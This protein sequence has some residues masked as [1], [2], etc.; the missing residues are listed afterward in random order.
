MKR[1][2]L[3]V[4][5]LCAV[6]F[7]ILVFP[8]RRAVVD[9]TYIHLQYARNLAETGQLAFNRGDPTYGA[10]SPLWAGGDLLLWCKILALLAAVGSIALVYRLARSLAVGAFA[11]AAAALI[12][13]CEAWLVRWSAVGMETPFAVFMVLLALVAGL[14]AVRS[15]GRSVLFG[16]I[17]FLAVLSRPEALALVV[18]SVVAYAFAPV[19]RA[20]RWLY[21]AAF[22]PLF[23]AWLYLIHRHTGSFFPL[24]AG[25]KQGRPVISPVVFTRALIPVKIMA[26]TIA[27]PWLALIAGLV[28]SIVRERSLTAL[29]AA[30]ATWRAE[31]RPAV[32]LVILW[33][34]ALPA[35]YVLFDFQ[36]LSRYLVPVIPGVIVLGTVSWERLSTVWWRG[37]AARR[38][39][40]AVFTVAAMAQSIVVYETTVVP[41]TEQFSRAF[42]AVVG[43]MGEWLG[44]HSA[45]EALVATPDI[46]VI[47]YVSQRR[48]LDLGGLVTPEINVMRRSIDVD[49]IID[50]GLYLEFNP[51]YLV[52]RSE[53]ADRFAG[54]VI[55]D[56]TFTPLGDGIVPNL[57]IRKPAP[58]VYVLYRIEPVSKGE[59]E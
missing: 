38:A 32:L 56:H 44:E 4:L 48:I 26:A 50:E 22:V 41:P 16:V 43:G 6:V 35:A 20:R 17:L 24:T 28:R 42:T 37:S 51:D 19:P 2:D 53:I 57:G 9:D 31:M 47:G 34:F 21:L 59:G 11:P 39:A 58:V 5:A 14:S 33:V 23:V 29:F 40:L 54:R 10:T 46:G 45:P 36:V 13:A 15:P 25:A 52:D 30:G 12:C 1:T 7:L 27:L 8:L 3:R 55:G 18:L 49:R